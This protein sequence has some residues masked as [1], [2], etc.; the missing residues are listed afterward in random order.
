[1]IKINLKK[2][3]LLILFSPFISFCL[4][5]NDYKNEIANISKELWNLSELGY[6]ENK[7]AEY[8]QSILKKMDLKLQKILQIFQQ[9]LLPAINMENHLFL[10]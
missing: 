4:E 6:L 8:I 3:Y 9:L 5:S 10:F 2:L 1:M 7:N